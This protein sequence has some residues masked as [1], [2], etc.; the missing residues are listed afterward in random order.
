[1]P[2]IR[3]I[4]ARDEENVNQ[5]LA[6]L[7]LAA[8]EEK[9]DI[10]VAVFAG[11]PAFGAYRLLADRARAEEVDF[12]RVRFVVFDEILR[13]RT[14]PFRAQLNERLFVPLSVPPDN[15]VSFNPAGD[16]A[17]ESRRISS[18]IDLAGIDIALLSADARG[19]IGFHVSG[20]ELD[21]STGIVPVEN[22]QR[23]GAESAFSLG[24][25]DLARA[26]KILLFASGKNLAEI[27]KNLTEGGYDPAKPISVLQR[28][29]N[30]ILVADRDALSRIEGVER[31]S[32]YHSGLFILDAATAPADRRVLVVSPHPDD[33]PISL[34]GTMAVLAAQ[35]RLVTAVMS[36]G[37]R[38]FI[39]GTQR[40]ERIAI[41]EAEVTKESR[42]LGVEPRFLR[43]PFYD[44]NYDVTEAD[45][46]AFSALLAELDPDWVFLPHKGDA[47]PAHIASRRIARESLQRLL[48]ASGRSVETWDY[49][50]PWAL[51]NRGDF[52][53]IVSVPR[54]SFEH[55][56][57][58]IR[59]HQSQ[60]SRTAYDVAAESL[61]RLR[62][63]L[64]PEAEL[65]GYGAKP[66][67]LEPYLELFYRENIRPEQA[68]IP[69]RG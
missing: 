60:V 32:G 37:H 19:H 33:A 28:H 63:A 1:M 39:Y 2:P 51:F 45:I 50:G 40:D 48:K 22:R 49:E 36:T 43:L 62:S 6:T 41:R 46:A 56:I 26:S 53:T 10:I 5:K 18:W 11:T 34:G 59:A 38:S 20:S 69:E 7:L 68:R 52:N 58:A 35:N 13:D 3:I 66:P 54:I 4:P 47:H 24:L 30:V 14:G 42:I 61:A 65:A 16:W 55:K 27:V 29:A 9:P 44:A 67:R 23:W 8:V 57:T 12:S 25:A 21:S 15:V 64:V 31:I 17:A